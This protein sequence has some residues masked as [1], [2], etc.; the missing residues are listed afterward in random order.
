[1]KR[2]L[3]VLVAHRLG[4]YLASGYNVRTSNKSKI[5]SWHAYRLTHQGGVHAS[6]SSK[7]PR[8]AP[9]ALARCRPLSQC[10]QLFLCLKVIRRLY[11]SCDASFRVLCSQCHCYRRREQTTRSFYR[12]DSIDKRSLLRYVSTRQGLQLLMC[13]GSRLLFLEAITFRPVTL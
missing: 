13:R 4:C 7:D 11:G 6:C 1:M 8:A 2:N 10:V 3:S 9:C 12:Y 5:S